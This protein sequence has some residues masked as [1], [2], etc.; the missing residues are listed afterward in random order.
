MERFFR[1]HKSLGGRERGQIAEITYGCLRH[2]RRLTAISGDTAPVALV[3][4]YLAT[5][6]GLSARALDAL[7][8]QATDELL[9]GAHREAHW[10]WPVATS[11]PDWLAEDLTRALGA[12]EA[13]ELARA[14]LKPAPLD[15]RCNTIRGERALLMEQLRAE[16]HELSPTPYSPWGLRRASRAP[17]FRTQAFS[18][19]RFEVQDEASQLIAPLLEARRGER[20]V[21]FC[22]GAGGKT[23][24]IGALMGNSGTLY[25][26]DTSAKRL[27]RMKGRVARA[28]LDNVRIQTITGHHDQKIKRLHGKIDRVLVDAPC[29]GTGTLRRSPDIKWRITPETVTRLAHEAL[30]ILAAA[31]RL[32]RPGGRLVYAT[33]SVLPAENEEVAAAFLRAHPEFAAIDTQ[34]ILTRRKIA[35]PDAPPGTALHLLPHRHGTDGFFAQAFD[36][37]P[38]AP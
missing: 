18:E 36:R 19:G 34:A 12:D 8:L 9:A 23:L 33:C 28:G 16:G 31:A 7:G 1:A 25:A 30:A 6:E 27:E 10:P 14:W 35:L 2:Y 26:F 24:H 37:R 22:A 3:G 15:I 29:S 13:Q 38:A 5:V 11:I 4:A 20:I 21:D 32:V 17:L